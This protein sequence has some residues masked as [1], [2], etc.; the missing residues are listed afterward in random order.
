MSSSAKWALLALSL[1]GGC[2]DHTPIGPGADV[3]VVH[4]VLNPTASVQHVDVRHSGAE[5]SVGVPV[6]GAIVTLTAPDGTAYVASEVRAPADPQGTMNYDAR[7]DVTAGALSI[8]QTYHLRVV[9]VD[10][11]ITEGDAIVPATPPLQVMTERRFD[12]TKD[13]LRLAWSRATGARAYEVRIIQRPD[14]T[15]APIV[16]TPAGAAE[17]QVISYLAYVDTSVVI[18]GMARQKDIRVFQPGVRYDVVVSAV[19]DHYYAYFAHDSDPYTPTALPSSLRG[20]IGV[21]GAVVPILE[22]RLM[23]EGGPPGL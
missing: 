19:D 13:T 5:L 17:V 2:L 8:E 12:P 6:H 15:G 14:S 21:F 10:G 22:Q 11:T 23:V 18:A 7:Y 3:V 4:A 1:V 9:T 20:G 16:F